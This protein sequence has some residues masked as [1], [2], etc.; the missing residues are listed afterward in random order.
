M[1][2]TFLQLMTF[3]LPILVYLMSTCHL[4][5]DK[6]LRGWVCL[7]TIIVPIFPM[8]PS[9][10][11]LGPKFFWRANVSW[12]QSTLGNNKFDTGCKQCIV[13][14]RRNP[15]LVPTS[16]CLSNLILKFFNCPNFYFIYDKCRS[17]KIMSNYFSVPLTRSE[18]F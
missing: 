10:Y 17:S 16:D 2:R 4:K 15:L 6:E 8:E 13:A 18:Y 7:T 9:P 14:G 5:S 12:K 11:F 3:Y 1:I